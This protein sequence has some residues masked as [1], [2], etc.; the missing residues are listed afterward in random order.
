MFKTYTT[1]ETKK[2]LLEYSYTTDVI[3]IRVVEFQFT[4]EK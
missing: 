2:V 1:A 4:Y 3:G